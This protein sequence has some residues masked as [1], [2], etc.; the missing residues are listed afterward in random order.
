MTSMFIGIIVLGVL[1][2]ALV[3]ALLIVLTLLVTR[4]REDKAN[5]E[6]SRGLFITVWVLAVPII[7]LGSLLS[8]SILATVVIEVILALSTPRL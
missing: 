7:A 2:L 6:Q 3:V 4:A 5:F 1:G 8:L